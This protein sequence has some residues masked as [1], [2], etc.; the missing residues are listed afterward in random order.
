MK[1]ILAVVLLLVASAAFLPAGALPPAPWDGTEPPEFTHYV[2]RDGDGACDDLD[3]GGV[4]DPV[5]VVTNG[6][7]P[8]CTIAAGNRQTAHGHFEYT[9]EQQNP[10]HHG[11]D[12]EEKD[13]ADFDVT[14]PGSVPGAL[15]QTYRFLIHEPGRFGDAFSGPTRYWQVDEW[16]GPSASGSR[17]PVLSWNERF[18]SC[19]GPCTAGGYGGGYWSDQRDFLPG[20]ECYTP[21]GART[22]QCGSK[23]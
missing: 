10:H 1:R 16:I 17:L 5:Q 12:T 21:T 19:S 3:G 4:A 11:R 22:E 18:F 23:N 2:D 15:G 8:P 14:S 20:V 7:Y 13:Y 6:I 9:H